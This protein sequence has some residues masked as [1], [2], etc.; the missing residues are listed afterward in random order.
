MGKQ[1]ARRKFSDD[2]KRQVVAETEAARTSV[3]VVA[4]RHDI[5]ANLLFRWRDD[6]RYSKQAESFL[7]IEIDI[8][9]EDIVAP[10]T[11][12]AELWIWIVG[13]VRL[14][15]KGSFDP[16]ALGTLITSIRQSS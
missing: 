11:D 5:N 9:L 7:P 8:G 13:D 1:R 6:P 3:S 2:F 16:V 14:V 10:N 15:I 12:F 4:R